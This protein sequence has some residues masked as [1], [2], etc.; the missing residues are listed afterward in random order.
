ML[1]HQYLEDSAKRFP[2]KIAVRSQGG[3]CSYRQLDN[4]ADGIA[5]VLVAKYDLH[6]A[7]IGIYMPKKIGAIASLFAVLKAGCAYV[8]LDVESPVERISYIV[9]DCEVNTLITDLRGLKRI[10]KN[11]LKFSGIKTVICIFDSEEEN[12]DLT[13]VDNAISYTV[14]P[15]AR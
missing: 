3:E 5:R 13:F 9:N 10:N 1:L 12:A 14:I 8:P 11:R 15:K 6:N 2:D 7:N 4:R